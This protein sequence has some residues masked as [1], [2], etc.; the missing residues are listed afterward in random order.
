M[1]YEDSDDT[2]VVWLSGKAGSVPQ[3]AIVGSQTKDGAPLYV[4]SV[5][6]IQGCY[7]ARNEF[8]EYRMNEAKQAAEFE[9]L[10]SIFGVYR[11]VYSEVQSF[12][13]YTMRHNCKYFSMELCKVIL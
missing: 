13:C 1:I 10:V 4:I 8:A 7:D 2:E 11:L 3:G 5:R 12:I 6:S 9:Y